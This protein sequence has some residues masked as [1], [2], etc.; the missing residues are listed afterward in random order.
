MTMAFPPK[1]VRLEQVLQ[2]LLGLVTAIALLYSGFLFLGERLLNIRL[3][4]LVEA[5]LVWLPIVSSSMLLVS[6]CVGVVRARPAAWIALFGSSLG[7]LYCG[8]LFLFVPLV[9]F[10]FLVPR[11]LLLF[12]VPCAL[13]FVTTVIALRHLVVR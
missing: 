2:S 3:E 9:L 10:T 6:A 8:L 7:W 12:F 13:L 5:P 1:R 4:D 11:V